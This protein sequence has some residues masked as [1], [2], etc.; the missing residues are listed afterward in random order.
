MLHMDNANP[1]RARASLECLKKC[2]IRL[3]DHPP[4]ST[5]LA[6]SE[7]CLFGKLK[8]AFAGGEFAATEELLLAIREITGSIELAEFESGFDARE[9]RSIQGIESQGEY[10]S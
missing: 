10:V 7:F 6:P 1:H 5:D 3:I 8:W 4:Y 9:R 2:R